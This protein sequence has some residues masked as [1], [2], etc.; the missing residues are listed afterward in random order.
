MASYV[1]VCVQYVCTFCPSA[2]GIGPRIRIE[3]WLLGQA[4][5][6]PGTAITSHHHRKLAFCTESLLSHWEFSWATCGVP[7][8]SPSCRVQH[9]AEF[10][11]CCR[12][13][14]TAVACAPIPP[15][16]RPMPDI[17]PNGTDRT[18]GPTESRAARRI[19]RCVWCPRKRAL[20]CAQHVWRT[21]T[22]STCPTTGPQLRKGTTCTTPEAHT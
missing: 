3:C 13:A 8:P 5:I 14:T 22:R 17:E 11:F 20:P 21:Q 2:Y 10:A 19:S 4:L 12:P 7:V 6:E 1:C 16:D 15:T 18:R 9:A